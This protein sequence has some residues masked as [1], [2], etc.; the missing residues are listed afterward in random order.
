[1]KQGIFLFSFQW[2]DENQS[3]NDYVRRWCRR[4]DVEYRY[5]DQQLELCLGGRWE[6]I[7]AVPQNGRVDVCLGWPLEYQYHDLLAACS[8]HIPFREDEVPLH[9]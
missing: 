2:T 3:I 8:R 1:M 7:E 4:H 5:K 9:D 6:T